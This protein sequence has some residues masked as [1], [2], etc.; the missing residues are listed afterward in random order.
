MRDEAGQVADALSLMHG[1]FTGGTT[2]PR[3]DRVASSR[4]GDLIRVVVLTRTLDILVGAREFVSRHSGLRHSRPRYT[5]GVLAQF[6]KPVLSIAPGA[7][8]G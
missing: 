3:V 2:G 1:R 7:V 4:D 5:R 8:S 6:A